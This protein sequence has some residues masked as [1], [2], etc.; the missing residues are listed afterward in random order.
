MQLPYLGQENPQEEEMATHS[1]NL[2]CKIP[3]TDEPHGQSPWGSKELDTTERA[4]MYALLLPAAYDVQ[5]MAYIKPISLT[6]L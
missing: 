5:Y 4:H 2:A 6:W 1:S 3:W